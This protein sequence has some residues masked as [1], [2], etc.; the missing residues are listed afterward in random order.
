[1]ADQ[2]KPK[3]ENESLESTE[4]SEQDLEQVA[5]GA[6]NAIDPKKDPFK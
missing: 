4:L 5:G 3:L 1:M 6:I 2:D